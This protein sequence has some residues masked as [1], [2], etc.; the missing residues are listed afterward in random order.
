MAVDPTFTPG[1][2]TDQLKVNGATTS[3]NIVLGTFWAIAPVVLSKS[4]EILSA[5]GDSTI[6]P[7]TWGLISD[8]DLIDSPLYHQ[9]FL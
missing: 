5:T 3:A 7:I 9:G 8:P 4:N 2:F 6:A 1:Y